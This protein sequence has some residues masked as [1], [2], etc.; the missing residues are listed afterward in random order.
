M[1]IGYA[2]VSLSALLFAA[3][4]PVSIV[5][6][7]GGV[8]A[9]YV[10]T[11]RL[12]GMVAVL[13]TWAVLKYRDHLRFSGR[14]LLELAFFGIAGLALMQWT[15]AEAIARVDIG[16]VLMI[17]YMAPFLIALYSWVLWRHRQQRAVWVSAI[18]AIVGLTMVL[19]V[20]GDSFAQLSGP[21]LLFA[22][23]TCL[24]FSYYATHASKLLR[25]RPPQVVLGL[26]GLFAVLFWSLTLA[27]IWDY[28]VGVVDGQVPLGG[29][30]GGSLSG[31]VLVVVGAVVGTAIPF[32]LFLSGVSRIGPTRSA[33]VLMLESV[34]AIAISWAWLRQS[35]TPMQVVGGL[36][37]VGA[38]LLL[39]VVR[40][41]QPVAQP[42]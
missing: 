29:N 17:E 4:G 34:A 36:V 38:V 33:I 24:I 5:L 6:I 15:Y 30:L 25:E 21:G 41:K 14:E 31:L 35:L 18:V 32:A 23:T 13:L 42:L 8:S 3:N 7:D 22:V 16:L 37:V 39:Q 40:Q 19:D 20:G 28:P 10:V 26:G 9:R 2:I 1:R 27:P 11:G 12:L